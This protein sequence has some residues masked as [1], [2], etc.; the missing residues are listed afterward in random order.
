MS[1]AADRASG[2]RDD[3][4]TGRGRRLGRLAAL[5]AVVLAVGTAPVW[6][7]R[8]LRR[9]DFFRVQRVEVVGA[10]YLAP[11]DVVRRMRVDTSASVWDDLA[12]LAARLREHPQIA[13]VDVGRRL[14]GTLVVR[15]RE[16]LPVAF[17]PGDGGLRVVDA[18]G[19]S[20]PI[21]PAASR[22]DLP[23]VPVR[24]TAVLRLLGELRAEAPEL[25]DR[26]SD[27]RRVG[28]ELRVRLPA[29]PVRTTADV[30][31]RRLTDILPVERDLAR[32]GAQVTELDLRFRDQV[33]AR[34]Q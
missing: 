15:V 8:L 21:D 22:L 1:G 23:V 31:A 10:R 3:E 28:A 20:L 34:L 4:P 9:L 32:R 14:P 29:F 12:P 17:I 6:G 26:V 7:P 30:T 16:R 13:E 11:P 2:G 19:V 25:F 27:V 5:G 33:I 24:D 18:R